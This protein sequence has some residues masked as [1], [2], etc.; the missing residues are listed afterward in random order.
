MFIFM[1]KL[2]GVKHSH[3]PFFVIIINERRERDS[4]IYYSL[5][6]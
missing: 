5:S 3:S 2:Y 6:I 4:Y 1:K